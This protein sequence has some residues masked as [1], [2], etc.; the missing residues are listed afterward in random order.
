MNGTQATF[1]MILL[2]ALRCLV[3]LVLVLGIGYVMNWLV[4]RW[5]AEAASSTPLSAGV[6]KQKPTRCW[7]Y[8]QCQKELRDECPGFKKQITPC[9]LLR[10]RAEDNLPDDCLTCPIYKESPSF[11]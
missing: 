4:D 8:I 7:A 5:E 10:T 3:P 11:A 1:T 6:A 9:W 2:F